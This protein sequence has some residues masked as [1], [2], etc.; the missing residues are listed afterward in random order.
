MAKNPFD[1]LVK[2]DHNKPPRICIAGEHG[3]GKTA[4]GASAPKPI[5]I[6]TEDGLGNLKVPAF[7]LCQSYGDFETYLS[8]LMHEDHDYKTVVIDSADWLDKLVSDD[9]CRTHKKDDITAFGYGEGYKLVASKWHEILADINQLVSRGMV[10]IFTVHT[11]VETR[12]DSFHGEYQRNGF[13]MQKQSGAVLQE[14]CDIIL[15]AQYEMR[16]KKEDAGFGAKR[17]RAIATGGRIM[18]TVGSPSIVAK[19][20]YNLPEVLPLSWPDFRA[21]YA[22]STRN[23]NSKKREET[24]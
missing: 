18:L 6:L 10:P 12:D 16:V 1:G 13:K 5:F 2:A 4:F 3:I 15:H 14:W 24:A 17:G 19:N 20:R 11:G 9:I 22:E 21:A 23:S 8:L 7:P